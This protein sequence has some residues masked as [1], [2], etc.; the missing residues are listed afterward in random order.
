MFAS[1][2]VPDFSVQAGTRHQ[3]ELRERAVAVVDGKAPLWTVAGLNASARKAGIETGMTKLQVEQFFDAV[4]RRRSAAEEA[5]AQAALLDCAAAFS[6]RVEDTAAGTVALD[7]AGLAG[8]FGSNAQLARQIARH[9][10]ELGF[11]AHVAMASNPD[12]AVCAARGRAGVTVIDCG[13]EAARLADLS[14]ALLPLET[15]EYQTL[16]R[17]GIRNFG[18]LARL[19][20]KAL[21][22]RLGQKGVHLHRLANGRAS[23]PLTLRQETLRFEEAL[24]LDYSLTLLEP[25]AFILHRLCDSLFNRLR[26]RSLAALELRLTLQREHSEPYLLP[27][28]LPVP[29]RNPRIVSRLLMLELESRPPGSPVTG[30]RIEAIPARPRVSQNGLFVPRAPEAE[31]LELTLARIA[32]LV[33]TGNVGSPRLK[34]SWERN[35]FDLERF[36]T[37]PAGTE[38]QPRQNPHVALRLFRPAL[39]ATVQVDHEI[40]TWIAFSGMHGAIESASGPWHSSGAWWRRSWSRDEWD[41]AVRISR[42]FESRRCLLRLFRDTLANRWYAE[43]IYD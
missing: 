41:V 26:S 6:P 18:A 33:G 7:A 32:A 27:L 8:L 1:I 31:K 9:V 24:E 43:G 38:L 35:Q 42:N 25:L 16:L 11:T 15:E 29:A 39:P 22:E 13:T 5:A 2:H 20:A 30:V 23:R 37:R 10:S 36:Q 14:I 3:P 28:R 21:A 17:W 19:P 4:I 34:D 40:P 12:A